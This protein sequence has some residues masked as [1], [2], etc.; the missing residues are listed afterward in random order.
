VVHGPQ[1]LALGLVFGLERI[2][3]RVAKQGYPLPASATHVERIARSTFERNGILAILGRARATDDHV[4]TIAHIHAG[5]HDMGKLTQ[6]V[7]SQQDLPSALDTG[8]QQCP[9]LLSHGAQH[10]VGTQNVAP[11]HTQGTPKRIALRRH[12]RLRDGRRL[13]PHQHQP[14]AQFGRCCRHHRLKHRLEPDTPGKPHVRK[15]A[16]RKLGLSARARQRH[17]GQMRRQG[18]DDTDQP[19]EQVKFKLEDFGASTDKPFTTSRQERAR[20]HPDKVILNSRVNADAPQTGQSIEPVRITIPFTDVQQFVTE[21]CL[22]CGC[23]S[24]NRRGFP[25]QEIRQKNLFEFHALNHAT[26]GAYRSPILRSVTVQV[27]QPSQPLR[28][29]HIGLES[30]NFRVIHDR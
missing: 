18:P 12:Q 27:K 22:R 4:D 3:H 14:H 11:T 15:T 1:E 8:L 25:A 6:P 21:V 28:I 26:E 19:C 10:I 9:F 23:G 24:V 13:K 5:K 20:A 7:G 30:G 17:L 16:L 2:R 29:E